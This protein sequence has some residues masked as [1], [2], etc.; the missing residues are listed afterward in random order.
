[1]SAEA[2]TGRVEN[3][4]FWAPLVCGVHCLLTPV[5]ALAAP[6]FATVERVEPVLMVIAASLG[7]IALR[8][9]SRQHGSPGPWWVAG[10]GMLLWVVSRQ[11]AAL[12]PEWAVAGAGGLMVFAGLLWNSRLRAHCC[13]CP[14]CAAAPT[15]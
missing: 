12:L 2:R 3:W 13:E 5:L 6:A 8:S 9:G 7:A 4:S 11:P 10:T 15:D 14:A 1:M